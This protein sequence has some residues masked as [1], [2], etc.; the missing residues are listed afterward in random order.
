MIT[1]HTA[2][3][4]QKTLRVLVKRPVDLR[5]IC[6]PIIALERSSCRNQAWVL[7]NSPFVPNGQNLGDRKCPAIREDRL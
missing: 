2:E 3:R 7:K 5:S 4:P 1:Q 6:L